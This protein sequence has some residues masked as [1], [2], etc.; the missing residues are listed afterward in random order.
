M[1]TP[2]TLV[3]R[4]ENQNHYFAP[5]RIKFG[6]FR[7]RGA[8]EVGGPCHPAP[9]GEAPA[10]VRDIKALDLADETRDPASI[11]PYDGPVPLAARSD[12]VGSVCCQRLEVTW[13]CVRV[14]RSSG[15]GRSRHQLSSR[16]VPLTHM[17]E[18]WPPGL[19]AQ[20]HILSRRMD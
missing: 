5:P 14:T 1:S 8:L 9:E 16:S 17:V 18:R 12:L 15:F 13:L 10:T 4:D 3:V 2:E 11:H 19:V 6:F 20:A 7:S